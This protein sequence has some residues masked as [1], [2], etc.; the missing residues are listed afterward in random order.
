MSSNLSESVR[1]N[2]FHFQKTNL[3]AVPFQLV[4]AVLTLELAV[5]YRPV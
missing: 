2:I 5:A 4:L 3:Q 1:R